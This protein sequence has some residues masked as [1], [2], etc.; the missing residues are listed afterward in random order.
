MF[1]LINK[2]IKNDYFYIRSWNDNYGKGVWVCLAP[3]SYMLEEIE[4]ASDAGDCDMIPA[5][6]YL[7]PDDA[8]WLPIVIANTFTE[9]L[10]Q[11]EMRLSALPE[12]ELNRNSAWCKAVGSVIDHLQEVSESTKEYGGMD[13]KFKTISSNYTQIFK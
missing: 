2:L 12:T 13:G 1:K 5:T 7:L 6:D 8:E 10:A 3:S 9:G 4:C 11:L